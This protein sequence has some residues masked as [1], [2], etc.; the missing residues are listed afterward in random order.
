V[1][2]VASLYGIEFLQGEKVAGYLSAVRAAFGFPD[3][4][5]PCISYIMQPTHAATHAASHVIVRMTDGGYGSGGVHEFG[6]FL[7]PLISPFRPFK[8]EI[9]PRPGHFKKRVI[10]G[11]AF[12]SYLDYTL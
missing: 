12:N 1:P 4:Y 9:L 10:P 8:R 2:S 11:I 5:H 3:L 6:D 7:A